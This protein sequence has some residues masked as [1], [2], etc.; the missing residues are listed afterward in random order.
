MRSAKGWPF[1]PSVTKYPGIG[2]TRFDFASPAAPPNCRMSHAKLSTCHAAVSSSTTGLRAKGQMV[3]PAGR[4]LSDRGAYCASRFA[5]ETASSSR[6]TRTERPRGAYHGSGWFDRAGLWCAGGPFVQSKSTRIKGSEIRGN[7]GT[8][9][10]Q[11]Q[12]LTRIHA[13]SRL[14]PCRTP[15][16]VRLSHRFFIVDVRFRRVSSYR[17]GFRGIRFRRTGF[18]CV[19]FRPDGFC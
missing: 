3:R 6:S 15:T 19:G 7:F 11:C 16:S 1:S 13:T 8:N 4:A 17:I 10:D 12:A 14:R 5:T 2:R 18:R 9:G